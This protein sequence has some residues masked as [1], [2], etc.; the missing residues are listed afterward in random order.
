MVARWRP[1]WS[2]AQATC[3]SPW[4]STPTVTLLGPG[5]AMVV[6]AVSLPDKGRWLRRPGGQHCDESV[7]TGSCQVT[8]AR[9]VLAWTVTAARVD[10]SRLR[11]QASETTG[12]TRTATT[13]RD[14]R[15]EAS[16][17]PTHCLPPP[18]SAPHHPSSSALTGRGD[19]LVRTAWR[20]KRADRLLTEDKPPPTMKPW[21]S[22]VAVGLS[23]RASHTPGCI[24]LLRRISDRA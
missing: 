14:H 22:P 21:A 2:R 4:V 19:V 7:A 5:C 9:L 3:T 13:A 12:Q 18:C 20:G 16:A 24:A 10:N 11:H 23:G 8:S 6:I 15:S 1:S 17:A